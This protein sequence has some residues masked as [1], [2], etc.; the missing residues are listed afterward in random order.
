MTLKLT[1]PAAVAAALAGMLAT[2]PAL[3]A[4]Y[5]Q[6]PG[7]SLVFASMDDGEIFTGT[8]PGF[9]TRVSFDP[10]NP[11]AGKL[12]V[13]IPLAG[14]KSGNSDR[15]STLQGKDF[16][17]VA[18]YAQARYSANGFRALGNNQY[19]ADGTLELH[20]A[21]KP[22]T[23]TFT[24]TPGAQP[25]LAGKATVKRLEFGVGGGDWAD[26]K[27]IPDETAISTI[28]RLKAR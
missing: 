15:D 28:V 9:Q 25:V 10:A 1:T 8:F 26:T 7:S 12:D 14:A 17:N 6:A 13:T 23:L 27:L 18:Q 19:A 3:A 5:E 21:S 20:G 16:F 24:W 22:V 11:A 4:D 2:A